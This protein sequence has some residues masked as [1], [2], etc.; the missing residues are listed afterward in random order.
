MPVLPHGNDKRD[1]HIVPAFVAK[2]RG[3]FERD[4]LRRTSNFRA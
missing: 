1:P 2:R 4:R 3:R